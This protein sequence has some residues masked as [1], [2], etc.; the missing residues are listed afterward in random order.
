MST[1]TISPA[2]IPVVQPDAA[3]PGRPEVHVASRVA[4]LST[5][6]PYALPRNAFDPGTIRLVSGAPAPEALP[7][8]DFA[9]LAGPLLGDPGTGAAA[10]AYGPHAGL[11]ALRDWIAGRERVD[12]AA[13]LITNGALHGVA[14]TFAALVEPGDTVVLDDPVFPDT[15]RLAE[16]YGGRVLPVRVG[17][18]GIDVQNLADQLAAGVRI[19][20]LYTVADFH[21]PS[22]GVLPSADR[23]RLVELAERY[24]FVIVSDNPYRDTTFDGAYE[25]DFDAASSRVVRVGSFTKTL[26]A[27]WRLGWVSGPSWLLPHLENVRRRSDF[28][29]NTVGQAL[30]LRLLTEPGWFDGLLE[31]NRTIHRT[32]AQVFVEALAQRTANELEFTPP[33]GGFFVWARLTDSAPDAGQ[34]VS[35]AADR[36][37]LITSGSHF[38]ADGGPQWDRYLR[39][40]FS[41]PSLAELPVAVDRLVDALAAAR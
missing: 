14:L 22:G 38:A 40:A 19:K 27:G 2:R 26:G 18:G 16:Q 36:Q 23:S 30:I 20:L 7:L 21:N 12:P 10:L 31:H 39:F 15:V 33:R 5:A 8:A 17:P 25:A 24:G 3:Q 11:P 13:V 32:K 6:A 34:L 28:H 35:A 41:A 37:L 4:N 1:A 9:R 29:S